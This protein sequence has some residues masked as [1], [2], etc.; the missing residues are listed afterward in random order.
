MDLA[1]PLTRLFSAVAQLLSHNCC[2]TNAV[3]QLLSHNAW[4]FYI[5]AL[6]GVSRTV[7]GW[8]SLST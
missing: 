5:Q 4:A 1:S 8:T 6:I 2:R 3:A 7:G